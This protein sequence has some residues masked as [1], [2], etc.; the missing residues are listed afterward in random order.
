MLC[1][2]LALLFLITS[3]AVGFFAA[4]SIGSCSTLMSDPV[5]SDDPSK[6]DDISKIFE[7]T[8]NGDQRVLHPLHPE[9]LRLPPI[10]SHRTNCNH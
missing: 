6:V 8:P 2:I 5:L 3:I 1:S 9:L 7:P 10:A 4:L